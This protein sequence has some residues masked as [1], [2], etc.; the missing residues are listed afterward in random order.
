MK[1]GEVSEA[2]ALLKQAVKAKPELKEVAKNDITFYEIINN[3]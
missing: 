1:E 3:I 2:T